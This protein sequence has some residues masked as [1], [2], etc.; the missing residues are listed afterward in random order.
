MSQTQ[1]QM[2]AQMHLQSQ[3]SQ[4]QAQLLSQ[5]SQL[6][7]QQSQGPGT[8]QAPWGGSGGASILTMDSP[9]G[10]SGA[11]S[12]RPTQGS[13]SEFGVGIMDL[14]SESSGATGASSGVG[15]PLRQRSAGQDH[16]ARSYFAK[17]EET[18]SLQVCPWCTRT[19][20]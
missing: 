19:T 5:Q 16:N 20:L 8:L 14:G 13:G 10:S 6:L 9:K 17:A 3:A 4:P 2:Q 1:A 7:S 11:P 12:L 15:G 18:Y